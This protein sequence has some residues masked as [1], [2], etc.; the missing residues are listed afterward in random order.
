M[1]R[2]PEHAIADQRARPILDRLRAEDQS[3]RDAGLP[4]ER[5]TRNVTAPTGKLLFSLVRSIEP[6]LILEIG[7]SN[8]YSTIWLA[9]AAREYG[10]QVIGSE[11]IPER[12][13]EAN[14]NL[15]MA[16][17]D[18]IAEVRA[19]DGSEISASVPGVDMV[20]LDAEKDDYPRLFESVVGL[21]RPGGLI[22]T[23]NVT[24]HD[25][26]ALL[27]MIQSRVDVVTQTIPFERGLEYTVKF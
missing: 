20:F 15:A 24:S 13:T 14:A 22:L 8:G 16:G 10:G 27:E 3:Q 25:C 6:K 11:I 21:V 19:G 9:L 12:A 23:D 4:V 7:S 5:R 1:M 26:S 17:L 2:Y 18:G